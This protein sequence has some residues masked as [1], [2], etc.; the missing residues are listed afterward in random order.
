MLTLSNRE[1]SENP[2]RLVVCDLDRFEIHTNFTSTA[3]QF[4]EFDLGCLADRA[5]TG[6]LVSGKNKSWAYL[7][8]IQNR[9][10]N[11][12]HNAKYQQCQE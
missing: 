10:E 7:T 2:Q 1:A 4:C 3:K 12:T 8:R 11:K 9:P 5:G 6:N